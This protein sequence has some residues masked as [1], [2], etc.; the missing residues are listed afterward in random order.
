MT[1]GE[2][3]KASGVNAKLIR[4]Y[5]SIGLIP[6]AARTESGYRFYKESDTQFLRFV[7]RARGLGFSMKEIKKLMG[8]WRNKTRASKEVKSLANKH[9]AELEFKIKEMQEMVDNLV[10]LSR[11][12]HGD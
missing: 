11:N 2:L 6:K 4:H 3:A 12:C 8:L 5:E 7:K 10:K 9:I 1:I